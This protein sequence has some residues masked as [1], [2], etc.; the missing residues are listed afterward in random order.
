MYRE[1]AIWF[2]KGDTTFLE[3]YKRTGRILNISVMSDESHSKIKVLNYINSPNITIRS[4]VVASSAIPYLLPACSLYYKNEKGAVLRYYGNGRLWRDGSM[5]QDIPEK[6]L[7]ISFRV[8]YPIVSQVNPHILPWFIR[9]KGSSG[10]PSIHRRGLGWRG[11]FFAAS[12]CSIFLLETKK[13]LAFIRDMELLPKINGSN[14]SN[15][16]LQSFEG[17]LTIIPK[18]VRFSNIFKFFTDPDYRRMSQFIQDGEQATWPAL[19]AISNRLQIEQAIAD[20]LRT[21]AISQK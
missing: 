9:P 13:W 21:H 1:E 11:G 3:A 6:E 16:W 4:A 17:S 14:F 7:N 18:R 2:C 19:A 5:R 20:H 12:L 15:L 8:K 10:S